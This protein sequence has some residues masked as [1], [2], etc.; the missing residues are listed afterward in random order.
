VFEVDGEVGTGVEEDVT[1]V[2]SLALKNFVDWL[3]K[4]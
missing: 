1:A 3:P 2:R 4:L